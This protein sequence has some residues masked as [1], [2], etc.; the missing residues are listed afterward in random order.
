[1]H[2]LQLGSQLRASQLAQYLAR[3][4]D[5]GEPTETFTAVFGDPAVLERELREYLRNFSFPSIRLDF[6]EKVGGTGGWRR[7]LAWTT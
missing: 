6:G 1:M 3:L 4:H 7:R 2:Y 5:G